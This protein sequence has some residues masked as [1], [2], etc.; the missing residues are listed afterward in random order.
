[1]NFHIGQKIV[2]VGPGDYASFRAL[3]MSVPE[4][5]KTYTIRARPPGACACCGEP[6]LY[7][8][9]IVNPPFLWR[10]GLLECGFCRYDFRPLVERK[11]DISIFQ[12]M[13]TD[14]RVPA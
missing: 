11:T 7:L 8:C 12:K 14:N 10:D 13:L 5:R 1:M 4:Y 2:F 9:E 6:G 3:G